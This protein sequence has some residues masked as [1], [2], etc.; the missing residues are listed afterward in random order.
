MRSVMFALTVVF[1]LI[2]TM[3]HGQTQQ[4]LNVSS[5]DSLKKAD[6]TL[7]SVYKEVMTAVPEAQKPLIKSAELAWI[8][9]RDKC[10][11]SE[12]SIYSGGSIESM[13]RM[14]AARDLTLERI[15]RL[16]ALMPESVK[17]VKG[18][19]PDLTIL[20]EKLAKA[21]A[22][23]NKVYKDRMADEPLPI[24]KEAQLA[25]LTYR[26]ACI[27]SETA[28]YDDSK[29]I[30]E[31]VMVTCTTALTVARTERLKQLFIERY[32]DNEPP[33]KAATVPA[34]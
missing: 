9:Y 21:D 13:I 15:E 7:N 16:R 24:I 28:G 25:W 27:K 11:D 33:E 29:A 5:S 2:A 34:K 31:K 4:E 23:M 32:D 22:K 18:S 6:A 3:A 14:N 1:I 30:A 19:L 26:D 17:K 12:G 8:T 20:R 10:V